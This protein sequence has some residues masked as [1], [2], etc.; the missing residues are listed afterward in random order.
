MH[1]K[2][3][4]KVKKFQ[5]GFVWSF[6]EKNDKK[7]TTHEKVPQ[8]AVSMVS[9]LSSTTYQEKLREFR[10]ESLEDKR[11]KRDMDQPFKILGGIDKVAKKP[12]LYYLVW[13]NKDHYE[14]GI[15]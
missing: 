9:G 4:G 10:L 12:C 8:Q 11:N 14:W 7:L 5:V 6:F 15:P 13:K 3:V 1:G 2:Y